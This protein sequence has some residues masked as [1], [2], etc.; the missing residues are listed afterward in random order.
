MTHRTGVVT[1]G[2]LARFQMSQRHD[3]G[4][5][6]THDLRI[7]RCRVDDPQWGAISTYDV[8]CNVVWREVQPDTS[9]ASMHPGSLWGHLPSPQSLGG[10]RV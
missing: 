2:S 3:P 7:K 10:G 4:G 6:R 1:S 9:R 8:R 5:F